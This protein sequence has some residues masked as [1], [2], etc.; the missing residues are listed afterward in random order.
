MS[1]DRHP[2]RFCPLLLNTDSLSL[3]HAFHLEGTYLVDTILQASHVV[4]P[5]GGEFLC[6]LASTTTYHDLAR[7]AS[8][9]NIDEGIL[10]ELLGFLNKVGGLRVSRTWKEQLIVLRLHCLHLLLGIWYAPLSYRRNTSNLHLAIGVLRATTP[11]ILATGVVASLSLAAGLTSLTQV[12]Q[13]GVGWIGIFV[14]SIFV[15]ELA[16]VR[17]LKSRDVAS[18]VLQNGMR[19][20]VIHSRT[21]PSIELASSLAGP[22]AGSVLCTI[23]AIFFQKDLLG[24]SALATALCHIVSLLPFYG[25]G[26]SIRRALR[27]ERSNYETR[28]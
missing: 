27:K 17:V 23:L 21:K 13:L 22:L 28:P 19:L 9:R 8:Q 4:N 18:D 15:H 25:D 16:H 2:V 26:Q 6:Q 3:S 1:L 14:G 11:V 10:R 20:G 5:P 12:V 24:A 7:L